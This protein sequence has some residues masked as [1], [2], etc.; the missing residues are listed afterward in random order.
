MN[1]TELSERGYLPDAALRFGMRVLNRRRLVQEGLFNPPVRE[2]RRQ[3]FLAARRTG[4]VAPHG[5]AARSQHYEVPAAFYER[6]LGPR[7]KYSSAWFDTGFEDLAEGEEEMLRRTSERAGVADGMRILDLGCGWGSLSLWLAENYRGVS[8]TAV[9][10]SASQKA[11]IEAR[12][13]EA[14]FDNLEV[15]TADVDD[16]QAR[17]RFDRVM[18]VEMFEHLNNYALLL[19]RIASWLTDD[20]RAFV[21]I[22]CHRRFGYPFEEQVGESGNWMA[23]HFFS[24]GIMPSFDIFQALDGALVPEAQW[25]INGR[26]YQR[27]CNLWLERLDARRREIGDVMRLTYGPEEASLWIQRWRMFFMACAELFGMNAGRSWGVGHYL[28]APR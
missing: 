1:L 5:D 16:F 17:G 2:L 20:G 19:E 22:F 9:S 14:G 3:R 28:L 25:F 4:P 27:T 8:I 11:F 13:A 21:H 7:L 12:A 24:G 18:S 15:I 23:R 6:V 26:H 10:N